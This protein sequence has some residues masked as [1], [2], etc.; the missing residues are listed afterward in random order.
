M[1]FLC[2]VLTVGKRTQY[3]KKK[4][5]QE[6][7]RP[8]AVGNTYLNGHL[9][10][11]YMYF[12]KLKLTFLSHQ[13]FF[14]KILVVKNISN[15]VCYNTMKLPSMFYIVFACGT[16]GNCNSNFPNPLLQQILL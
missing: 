12:L 9:S 6:T 3:K 14:L 7:P 1:C 4:L 2:T 8:D 5:E 16:I 10:V 15:G 11:C 13:F